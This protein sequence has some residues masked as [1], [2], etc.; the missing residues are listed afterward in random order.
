MIINWK[1]EFYG[2][3]VE[4]SAAALAPLDADPT[5]PP[6]GLLWYNATSHQFKGQFSGAADVLASKSYVDA[7][8]GGEVPK[9]RQIATAAPLTGG[10][11]LSADRTLGLGIVPIANGGTGASD[12][13]TART[14]LGLGS[15]ATHAAGDFDTAGAA[16]A[17]QAAS[18]PAGSA[19][20]VGAKAFR[21]ALVTTPGA[22]G[23]DGTLVDL[24]GTPLDAVGD[25]VDGVMDQATGTDLSSFFYGTVFNDGGKPA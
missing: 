20:A 5:T 2:F 10:G 22:A 17:A 18:D 13:A 16:A 25:R 12:A 8:I 3:A 11:D 15:A 4:M 14:N 23:A 19:A 21:E 24:S 6:E 9:T 7:Q 1:R